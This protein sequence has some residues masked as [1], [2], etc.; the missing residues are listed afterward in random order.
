MCVGGMGGECVRL[1]HVMGAEP[2]VC[3]CAMCGVGG[4]G[5]EWQ[6]GGVEGVAW[7]G[8]VSSWAGS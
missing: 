8:D 4:A 2:N 7:G 1:L 3:V 5:W 6:G